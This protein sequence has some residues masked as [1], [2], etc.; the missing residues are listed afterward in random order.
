LH[1]TDPQVLPAGEL[2][3]WRQQGWKLTETNGVK[4]DVMEITRVK[5]YVMEIIRAKTDVMETARVES[6]GDKGSEN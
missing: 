1:S 5:N 3:S 4:T 2:T 6:D